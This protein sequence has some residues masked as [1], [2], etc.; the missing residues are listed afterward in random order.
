MNFRNANFGAG[1]ACIYF[2]LGST[3]SLAGNT[4]TEVMR[5]KLNMPDKNISGYVNYIDVD[6]IRKRGN[7]VYFIWGT[8]LLDNNG[9]KK[10]KDPS[11]NTGKINCKDKTAYLTRD[12]GIWVSLS[13]IENEFWMRSYPI[14]CK[15]NKFKFWE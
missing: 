7:I 13:E 8:K 11:S 15:G 10:G 12:D 1:F 4:W 9:F 14:V 3:S 6:S 5:K 2:L